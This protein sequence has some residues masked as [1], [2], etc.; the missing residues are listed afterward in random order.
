VPYR[1][2]I[3]AIGQSSGKILPVYIHITTPSTFMPHLRPAWHNW[4][5]RETFSYQAIS[6]L[7]VYVYLGISYL[8]HLDTNKMVVEPLRGRPLFAIVA[9]SFWWCRRFWRV[10]ANGWYVSWCGR[11]VGEVCKA[12][13]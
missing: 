10:E 1:I 6:R 4:L 8:N 3:E 12:F 9:D 11:D 7:R 13:V 2:Q 5:A